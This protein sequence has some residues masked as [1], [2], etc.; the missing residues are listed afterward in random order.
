MESHIKSVLNFEADGAA[1][2]ISSPRSLEACL[3]SGCDP[4]ELMPRRI[5]TFAVKGELPE[6]AEIRHNFFE[7]R[8]KEKI[9]MVKKERQ[10]I[11][12]FLAQKE[13]GLPALAKGG[14]GLLAG[15]GGTAA[16]AT[17]VE[18]ESRRIKA[19]ILEIERKRGLVIAE[20]QEKEMQRVVENEQRMAELHKKIHR[21]E[22]AD[23][24]RRAEHELKVAQQK[25]AAAAKRA[26]QELD[27]YEREK[28][29][30]AQRK[31]MIK[32]AAEMEMRQL[33]LEKEQEATRLAEAERR[34]EDRR[35]L[36][37]QQDKAT[38]ALMQAQEEKAEERKRIMADREARV[39]AQLAEKK[40]EKVAEV[41]A[42][43]AAAE[44]RI[45]EVIEKNKKIQLDKKIAYDNKVAEVAARKAERAAEEEARA[46]KKADEQTKQEVVRAKRLEASYQDRADHRKDILARRRRKDKFYGEIRSERCKELAMK[47]LYHDLVMEAKRESI[48]RLRRVDEFVRIQTLLRIEQETERTEKIKAER[49]FLVEQRIAAASQAIKKKHKIKEAMEKMRATN[50][51]HSLDALL[52]GLD[53]RRRKSKGTADTE[54]GSG[55]IPTAAS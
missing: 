9:E 23:A 25:A 39:Q 15:A 52:D 31:E 3:R 11:I 35:A 4:Q 41:A 16:A 29:D 27:K 10:S 6:L 32:H 40:A 18:M 53:R 51:F 49:K 21:A 17:D 37:E 13:G 45:Q 26:K 30:D 5:K 7:T 46:K 33:Q 42:Q 55:P 50:N 38:I 43:R 36:K 2:H 22:E 1:E 14:S 20:R 54:A 48:E 24:K 34:E 47:K 44:Q 12:N 28:N 19:G 8:R